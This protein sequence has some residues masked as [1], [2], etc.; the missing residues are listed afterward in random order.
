VCVAGGGQRVTVW[1]DG[2]GTVGAMSDWRVTDTDG[3]VEVEAVRERDCELHK[4][5]RDIT[6]PLDYMKKSYLHSSS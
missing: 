6:R 3:W 5:D 4:Q 1:R 2:R